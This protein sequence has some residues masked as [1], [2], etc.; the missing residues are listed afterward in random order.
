MLPSH[1]AP[2]LRDKCTVF[3]LSLPFDQCESHVSE[4]L[5]YHMTCQSVRTVSYTS[6][7][8]CGL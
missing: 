7:E 5:K 3:I 6:H 1:F 4:L 8:L 2:D